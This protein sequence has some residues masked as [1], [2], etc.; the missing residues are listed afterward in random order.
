MVLHI[1][2]YS[3]CYEC[4]ERLVGCSSLALQVFFTSC[5]HFPGLSRCIFLKFGYTCLFSFCVHGDVKIVQSFR[6]CKAI[7]SVKATIFALC[8]F[9]LLLAQIV[10]S[11]LMQKVHTNV[12][13]AV[14]TSVL[15][16]TSAELRP[17]G[18]VS[19]PVIPLGTVNGAQRQY[20]RTQRKT[21]GGKGKQKKL[22]VC[23]NAFDQ[24]SDSNNVLG[25]D[26]MS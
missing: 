5:L 20:K 19:S 2:E 12:N 8:L 18:K 15:L 21:R 4:S 6:N 13:N 24:K 11:M 23:C 26:S 25:H 1:D 16:Y 9:A 17:V 3:H 7:F 10:R 14:H 22:Q